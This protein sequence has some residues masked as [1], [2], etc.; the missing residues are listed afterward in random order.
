VRFREALPLLALA[1]ACNGKQSVTDAATPQSA[2]ATPS[3]EG[4]ADVV[5]VSSTDYAANVRDD[6]HLLLSAERLAEAKRRADAGDKAWK[7]LKENVDAHMGTPSG[8]RTGPENIATVYLVTGD[9][10]YCTAGLAFALESMKIDVRRGSY[11][12]Y[13]DRMREAAMVL[14]ACREKLAPEE[15][16]AIADHL[17]RW[18]HELWFDNQ[19]SGW[20]L[21]D[22]G[23]NYFMAFL[24]GTAFAGYTLLGE[25]H[26]NA[27]KYLA[28]LR[29][30]IEGRVFPYLETRA[31][32]GDF[33]EGV[34][35]GQ[36]SKQRLFD[37][38]AIIASMGGP[39]HFDRPF[40]SEA[41]RYAHYQLQPDRVSIYPGGDLARDA[42]M[43]VSPLDRDYLLMAVHF[44]RD[45]ETRGLGQWYL[46]NVVPSMAAGDFAWRGGLYRDFIFASPDVKPI[47]PTKLPLSYRAEGTGWVNVRTGWDGDATSFSVAGSAVVDQSHAHLDTGSFTL[48]KKG[49][50]ALDAATIS[51]SGLAWQAGAHNMV[52]VEGHERRNG[53]AGGGLLRFEHRPG[54]FAYVQV[55]ASDLFRTKAGS[56]VPMLAEY[57]RELVFLEPNTLVVFDRVEAKEGARY[58]LRFHVAREPMQ[59]GRLFTA[60]NGEGSIAYAVVIGGESRVR[61]DGDLADAPSK[62][63]RIETEAQA[64]RFLTVAEVAAGPPPALSPVAVK[65]EGVAGVRIGEQVV[66]FS[67]APRGT[68]ASAVS[69]RVEGPAPK[70]HIL[71]NL[72]PNAGHRVEIATTGNTTTVKLSPGGDT[73]TSAEGLLHLEK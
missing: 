36:R 17:D 65:G 40:V 63:F 58:H 72:A 47:A 66:V 64:G 4:S 9:A 68:P 14:D 23:N 10:R 31:K 21:D 62:T 30:K 73:R 45:E 70:R 46:Q 28:L 13:G 6:D 54:V 39:N 44:A 35:Y 24:E 16:K 8:D 33:H 52:T 60:Q 25:K 59:K 5:P 27:K 48:F 61:N 1:L 50:Q 56:D 53:P 3:G 51:S 2:S 11:L 22:P 34:N 49:W 29:D 20:S 41:V 32:G 43:K 67:D 71:V 15:R 69:Y 7:A 42:A 19:G 26:P 55:D 18:T 57:T 37:A 38:F 12:Y